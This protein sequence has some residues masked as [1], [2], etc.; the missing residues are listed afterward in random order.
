MCIC[1]SGQRAYRCSRC[2]IGAG[3]CKEHGRRKSRCT[4]CL[5]NTR[6]RPGSSAEV[7]SHLIQ[8]KY[9]KTCGGTHLC[10]HCQLTCVRRKFELCHSC[11][12]W[13]QGHFVYS[14][15]RKVKRLLDTAAELGVLPSY[16]QYNR[17]LAP[18]LDSKIY[19]QSRPDFLWRMSSHI[20]IL[21]VDEKQHKAYD[22]DCERKR[23]LD[24]LNS[25]K[26]IPLYLVRYNPDA[27]STG[28]KTSATPFCRREGR[29]LRFMETVLV[30]TPRSVLFKNNVFVKTYLFYDCPCTTCDYIHTESYLR[31]TDFVKSY[32]VVSS[33]V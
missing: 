20:V 12:H 14:K 27:F 10:A 30:D 18:N 26:G 16:D 23:E 1:G 11:S 32:D 3:I 28:K 9:C 19:G 24:L 5:N 21:E 31:D 6:L 25:A 7:C 17:R 29:F 8:K 4:L 33:H 13:T 22:P 2:R 15:E